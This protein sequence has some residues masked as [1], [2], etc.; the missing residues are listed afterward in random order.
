MSDV[1]T[2]GTFTVLGA[3]GFIGSNLVRWLRSQNVPHWCPSR[4]TS[5]RGRHLSH[6]VYC[7]GLTGD[8][9]ERPSET[10]QAH[11]SGLADVLEHAEFDSFLYL[12]STRIYAGVSRGTEDASL[13]V[14]PNNPEDLYNLSK[15]LGESICI[16]SRRP[17]VRIV[18]LS[19]VYGNDFSSQNFLSSVL[20]DVVERRKVV[21]RTSLNSEKDYVSID[22]VVDILPSISHSGQ[23]RIY[24][25][26]SGNNTSHGALVEKLVQ[27][28][29]CE[30]QVLPGTPAVRFPVVAIDRVR[31]EFGFRPRDVLD[32]LGALI[33]G[34]RQAVHED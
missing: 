10:V 1:R 4:E 17:N 32:S 21:L 30:V 6:V 16:S 3:S 33:E 23:H 22:D 11:V 15:L 9:R 26:A 29:G 18:R 20:R 34:Y 7:I 2:D 13:E 25:V 31:N 27:L 19:N 14:N 24:N 5:L 8:F 12:S 28:T